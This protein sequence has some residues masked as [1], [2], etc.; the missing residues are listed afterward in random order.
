[1]HGERAVE[2]HLV[3]AQDMDIRTYDMMIENQANEVLHHHSPTRYVH[4]EATMY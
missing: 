4:C 1:M 3:E 2:K